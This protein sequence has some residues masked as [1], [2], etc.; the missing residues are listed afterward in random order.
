M[1]SFGPLFPVSPDGTAPV[2]MYT[3]GTYYYT[4]IN[5]DP[6]TSPSTATYVNG[7]Y[8]SATCQ[9]WL[10]LDAMPSNFETM[11]TVEMRL[12][13][14]SQGTRS[15]DNLTI[16]TAIVTADSGTT[17]LAGD[18]STTRENVVTWD[19]AND[20][21]AEQVYV[22]NF[23]WVNT[24]ADKTTWDAAYILV[25]YDKSKGGGWDN[26][27]LDICALEVNGDYDVAT[28]P[29]RSTSAAVTLGSL[30][31]SGTLTTITDT[32]AGVTLG[33]LATS[34][35][36]DS[37]QARDLDGA[38]TLGSFTLTPS[39]AW[40]YE[41]GDLIFNPTVATGEVLAGSESSTCT[42]VH[43]GST[44]ELILA[45][46]NTGGNSTT[47]TMPSGWYTDGH[48]G[49]INDIAYGDGHLFT[50]WRVL[51]SGDPSSF[52]FAIDYSG[53]PDNFL[54][55]AVRVTNHDGSD[56]IDVETDGYEN[57][58]VDN[59][60]QI[61]S[62][63]TSGTDEVVVAWYACDLSGVGY[64][65]DYEGQW[66]KIYEHSDANGDMLT[67]IFFLKAPTATTY[68]ITT[69][70]DYG[71]FQQIG[72][73]IVAINPTSGAPPRST[74]AAV[75]LGTLAT[76]G[77]LTTITDTTAGVTLGSL[78]TAGALSA[79]RV[80][81]AGVSL[82]ALASAGTLTTIT[83]C[84]AGVTL[85]ALATS[86]ALTQTFTMTGTPTLGGLATGINVY[87]KQ[88][89]IERK[90]DAGAFGEVYSGPYEAPNPWTDTGPFT[91]GHTY[92]YRAKWIEGPVTSQWSNEDAV[93]FSAASAC[94]AAVT[95]GSLATSGDFANAPPARDSDVYATLGSL[96]TAGSLTQT[97]DTTAGVTLGSLVSVGNLTTITDTSAALSIGSLATSGSLTQ[98]LDTTAAVTL[99]SLATA[100]TLTQTF[101]LT[102]AVTLG[103][104][105]SWGDITAGVDRDVTGQG[106][107]GS[108]ATSGSFDVTNPPRDAD[109]Y[110][111]L[112]SLATAGNIQ[113]GADRELDGQSNLGSFATAGALSQV[114]DT[115]AAVTLGSLASTGALA[116]ATDAVG[117]PTLG[118]LATSGTLSQTLD[119][120]AACYL[121]GFATAG[122]LTQTLDT[123]ATPTLGSLALSAS[124]AVAG[125]RNVTAGVTLGSLATTGALTTTL[126][127][128]A[129]VTL[130]SLASS[131]QA[132]VTPPGRSASATLSLGT[133][134]AVADA[135]NVPPA[136]D[137][138]VV[139]T[140]G[141]LALS[142]AI[143]A[144]TSKP[145][146]Y[147]K[148]VLKG[149]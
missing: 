32:T 105:V 55:N 21:P 90:E 113:A 61:T 30:A 120:V 33:S 71:S 135:T 63:T 92:T 103:S 48:G 13:I 130:G 77:T 111:S 1:T 35:S 83:D 124:A 147:R 145:Y 11:N 119:T 52:D 148:F 22:V 29:P 104:L 37:G 60:L 45:S 116:A 87:S 38:M 102:A 86:G 78:A 99:G 62:P 134:V 7:L 129:A 53:G 54:W 70:L 65:N 118:S 126:D 125:A 58:A 8:N 96:A 20:P 76:S 84:T 39:Y 143:H 24:T 109:V 121:G 69:E 122:S 56:P 10:K 17:Q 27:T 25:Q 5:S 98:I 49:A 146:F 66:H 133:L 14:K 132:F 72:A 101:T 4:E 79:G 26:Y 68:S 88:I 89:T 107:L 67:T 31:T 117:T 138:D 108:L 36:L 23:S 75:T 64:F 131:G 40:V 28:A 44:G 114:F 123:T 93:I 112:G 12:Y 81:S 142:A 43:G 57:P 6:D 137:G 140:L 106:T 34:G 42:I 46:V 128:T 100:G 136:R 9:L 15:N 41:T 59:I 85:G 74:S 149:R 144:Y 47:C 94:S 80:T 97:L 95:L 16:S 73:Q 139:V 18:T 3:T 141:T 82:G 110:A 19:G 51:Q 91:N 2:S 115:T 50:F 127:A